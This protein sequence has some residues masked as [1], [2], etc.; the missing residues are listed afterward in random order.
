M[1]RKYELGKRAEQQEETR[2]RIVE[3]AVELHGT[4]GPART[5]VGAIAA[6][7]GVER[8]TFYRHFTSAGAVLPACT[9]HFRA[10]N[11]GPDPQSW[12]R[13]RNADERLRRALEDV[14]VY[15]RAN[16]A[17]LA[18]V[19]RDRELGLPVGDGVLAL[20][21]AAVRVLGGARPRK[22]ALASLTLAFDFQAWRTLARVGLTDRE[23]AK[24]AR[25][26]VAAT[27]R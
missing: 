25:D 15:Y 19:L 2:R 26:L 23:A 16:E 24:L 18:N 11:P 10:S 12:V 20:R 17:M 9:A 13:I 7:A 6:R 3:A 4:L 1:A 8:K 21:A 5:T 27:S 14:Y 22:R